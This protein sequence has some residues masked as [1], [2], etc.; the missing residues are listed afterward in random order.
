M[1]LWGILFVAMSGLSLAVMLYA[2]PFEKEKDKP[3]TPPQFEADL[4]P[5][6]NIIPTQRELD[7]LAA[8]KAATTP[9]EQVEASQLSRDIILDDQI[10]GP[11]LRNRI[12]RFSTPLTSSIRSR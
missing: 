7:V 1:K 2:N 11:G 8:S 9:P 3:R 6:N 12:I 10:N 4:S 5:E